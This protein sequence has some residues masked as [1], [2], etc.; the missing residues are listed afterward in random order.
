MPVTGIVLLSRAVFIVCNVTF[1]VCVALCALF[2]LSVV[3]FC[4]LYV[5]FVCFNVVPLLFCKSPFAVLLNNR[6]KLNT[7]PLEINLE[8]YCLL[9]LVPVDAVRTLSLKYFNTQ[10][11][12]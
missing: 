6:K 11:S 1:I 9:S 5:F 4:V 2:C 10:K 12:I 7:V 8:R 3:L